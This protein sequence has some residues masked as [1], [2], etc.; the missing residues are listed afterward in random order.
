MY[1]N[2]YMSRINNS[3]Y[4]IQKNNYSTDY[5]MYEDKYNYSSNGYNVGAKDIFVRNNDFSEELV[6]KEFFS[7]SNIKRIQKMIKNEISIRSK[8]KIIL[9]DDQ[10][11]D[12]LL[13]VMRTAYLEHGR[14][15][16]K[17]IVHQVKILNKQL[18]Q[19]IVPSILTEIKQYY[20]YLRDINGPLNP[21]DRPMNV[22]N[23]G[24]RTLPSLTSIW[25]I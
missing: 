16:Q 25:T 23:A 5:D 19:D 14:F 15:I 1:Y 3:Q 18:I 24:R 20:G 9:K 17:N 4:T 7:E 11:V 8:G 13:I 2:L 6:G 12:D 22:S 10:S 21:I